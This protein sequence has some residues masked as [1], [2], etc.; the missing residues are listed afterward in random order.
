MQK[1][2][3]IFDFY[4][5]PFYLSIFFLCSEK[6]P[7]TI[8]AQE[9]VKIV[10]YRALY[11]FES[12]SHDEISIQ[13]GDIV[14]VRRD[15]DITW[16]N[17]WSF[18][19][20]VIEIIWQVQTWGKYSFFTDLR[21]IFSEYQNGVIW[22]SKHTIILDTFLQFILSVK[23]IHHLWVDSIKF[24]MLSCVYLSVCLERFL[25]RN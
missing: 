15:C 3:K 13:P 5:F 9:D 8:S 20:C 19:T 16:K 11:P 6:A 7:L 21:K 22:H 24:N 2:K 23:F 1:K 10:Y 25:Q 12:R 4:V 18:C 17:Y 14:M